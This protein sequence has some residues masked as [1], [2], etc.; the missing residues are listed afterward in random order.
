MKQKRMLV[1][2]FRVQSWSGSFNIYI[3][4]VAVLGGEEVEGEE[5][6]EVRFG[7]D[8]AEVSG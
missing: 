5:V 3:K 2:R 8:L 6:D 7:E 1:E 4:A